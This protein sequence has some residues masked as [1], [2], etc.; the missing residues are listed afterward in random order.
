MGVPDSELTNH[1]ILGP[2]PFE[3]N[4]IYNLLQ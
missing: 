2:I 4:K 1:K 3:D